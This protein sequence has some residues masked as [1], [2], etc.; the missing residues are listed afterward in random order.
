M[1]GEWIG[2]DAPPAPP[3]IEPKARSLPEP[4]Q[5]PSTEAVRAH[6]LTHLPHQPW[7]VVCQRARGKDA[8]HRRRGLGEVEHT[9]VQMDYTFAVEAGV[10]L[11]ILT[12]RWRLSGFSAATCVPHKGAIAYAV[13][14]ACS[15]LRSTGARPY[16]LLTDSESSIQALGKAVVAQLNNGSIVVPVATGAHQAVG[17]VERYHTDL[18]GAI[19]AQREQMEM[20]LG[21]KLT[22][23]MPI[24][25]W[26][27]R[28]TSWLLPR[29]SRHGAV[30]PY[31]AV[32]G[33]A[34]ASQLAQFGERVL[35]RDP[36]A[37]ESGYG[38]HTERWHD[39]LW[40]GRSE[41]SNTHLCVVIATGAVER[42]RSVKRVS[43]MD[44][45]E[46]IA[47]RVGAFPWKRT[48]SLLPPDMHELPEHAEPA[49]HVPPVSQGR[50]MTAEEEAAARTAVQ[51][52]LASQERRD[53]PLERVP[54]PPP[55][56][57][58][59]GF[60]S[61]SSQRRQM[62]EELGPT[63]GCPACAM[64]GIWSHGRK[65][66]AECR[67][68]RA[69]WE[70]RMAA[71]AEDRTRAE[72]AATEVRKRIKQEMTSEAVAQRQLSAARRTAEE[73][74]QPLEG[75]PAETSQEGSPA[76]QQRVEQAMQ[77]DAVEVIA[78]DWHED[79]EKRQQTYCDIS[80]DL[81][82]ETSASEWR[83]AEYDKVCK[84]GTFAK[85]MKTAD[86]IADGYQIIGSRFM[87]DKHKRKAR[88]VVQDIRRGPVQPEHWAPTPGLAALRAC[89]VAG[90][91]KQAGATVLDISSAFLHALLSPDLKIA[92]TLPGEYKDPGHVHVLYKSLYGLRVAPTL[93]AEHLASSL[94]ALG[95]E[96]SQIEA[97]AYM[98]KMGDHKIYCVV[99]VD[100]MVIIGSRTERDIVVNQLQ[101][102]YE[103]KHVHH[104]DAPGEQARL[105]G[106]TLIKTE[107]GF[108][109]VNDASHVAELQKMFG[110]SSESKAVT[111]PAEVE[112]E[113]QGE[114]L[115]TEK[116]A[117]VRRAIGK[118]MWISHDRPDLK[119]AV[120]RL[121]A[122]VGGPTTATW[123][124]AKRAT[125]YL[126]ANPYGAVMLEY[127]QAH[128][129]DIHV[130]Q[131]DMYADR[132]SWSP[133][134]GVGEERPSLRR[135]M[136]DTYTDS[137][138]ATSRADRK[139]ITGGTAFFHGSLIHC[140]S[141]KQPTVALSSAE[142]ELTAITTGLTEGMYLQ[143][144]AAELE[145]QECH[146]K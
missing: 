146:L 67:V 60:A 99:H 119:F 35:A 6:N 33:M 66:S 14:W 62:R 139:S 7:C 103:M 24:Y 125:R 89:L 54:V 25:A 47:L 126:M 19:R 95:F 96:R 122:Q 43:D 34:Y 144:L 112:R 11:T 30:T 28:H 32:F 138:W 76:K 18:H 124:E 71:G 140:W 2:S 22:L 17:A 48:E 50:R 20:S 118:I 31:E 83:K 9:E 70:V 130:P 21:R 143:H 135:V 1:M 94:Q 41:T 104:L 108:A 39:A 98:K 51:Q 58:R 26:L 123:A 75:H 88:L 115:S 44:K 69:E 74:Q 55:P 80:G 65:H 5:P 129:I 105:L 132:G 59:L 49:A 134:G 92:I 53:P 127:K 37:T 113:G 116:V 56:E 77:V 3:G 84:L 121:A 36:Q 117:E 120:G 64:A 111:T 85:R 10:T 40:L 87:V 86:A 16:R 81:I 63:E 27:V 106:R 72:D 82:D 114:P 13:H 68:R 4:V 145:G 52:A 78:S 101:E 23:Q 57:Q 141:K 45:L 128:A 131:V 97:A 15:L 136:L 8:A 46:L 133:E 109:L 110:L 61:M 90:S 102:E 107:R 12:M 142:A 73:K 93:W 38:K 79:V 42:F 137:D 29:F 91:R 100:D